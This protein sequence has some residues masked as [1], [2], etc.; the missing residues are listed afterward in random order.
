VTKKNYNKF[1]LPDC[2]IR[3]GGVAN[4]QNPDALLGNLINGTSLNL[5]YE[6]SEIILFQLNYLFE[7]SQSSILP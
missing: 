1:I 5:E 3:V 4:H 2:C 6:Y 7:Y